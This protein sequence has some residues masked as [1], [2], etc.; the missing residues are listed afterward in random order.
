MALGAPGGGMA[1]SA[2]GGNV[3]T[4]AQRKARIAWLSVG[5]NATLVA[6]KLVVGLAIGSVSVI[7]EAIHSGVDLLAAI[8]ALI[9]VKTSGLPADREHPYGHGKFENVSGVVEAL[10]I[11]VAAGWIIYEAVQKLLHPAPLQLATWGVAVM[12]L[13]AATNTLLSHWL[14]KIGRE[15]HS[16]A[17]LADAWHLRTD[18][19]TSAG[20]MVGLAAIW[21]GG[22]FFPAVDLR[23]VDPTAA[24]L[25]AMLILHAAYRLTMQSARDLVDVG[26][27]P[28]EEE[29][30]R[31][32]LADISPAVR[33]Y[34]KLRTRKAG[35]YRFVEAHV[36]VDPEMS[37][38]ASHRIT[39]EITAAINARF[40]GTSVT[41]HIEPCDRRCKPQCED[42]CLLPPVERRG[43]GRMAR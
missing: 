6:L 16:V 10:L 37:V 5:S 20:V 14:F 18:V 31:A 4:D 12:L 11:F 25:V 30:I 13:S 8:V 36:I 32:R 43:R 24:I 39:D 29:W 34:H 15:T 42:G 41:V 26:L 17:L 1:I 3:A 7:S 35:P 9:A 38:A 40:P 23:W 28:D 27:P 21:S 33:G 19:Y 2:K 22:V